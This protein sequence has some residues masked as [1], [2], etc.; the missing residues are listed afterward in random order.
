MALV[1]AAPISPTA[2]GELRVSAEALRKEMA[3]VIFAVERAQADLV[4]K[5]PAARRDDR[6]RKGGGDGAVGLPRPDRPG[7]R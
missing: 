7:E 1:A 2:A 3:E 6:R 5:V 4:D